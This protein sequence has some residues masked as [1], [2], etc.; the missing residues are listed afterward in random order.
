MRI[1]SEDSH[2]RTCKWLR[3]GQLCILLELG[4][5]EIPGRAL[6]SSEHHP[7][8]LAPLFWEI[9]PLPRGRNCTFIF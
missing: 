9:G 5:E 8:A 7:L 1:L 3:D 4:A 2:C 6:R